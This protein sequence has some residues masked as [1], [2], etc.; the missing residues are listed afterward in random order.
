MA[1]EIEEG[2]KLSH[3]FDEIWAMH[4]KLENSTDPCS[5]DT[6]QVFV[7]YLLILRLYMNSTH[8]L[9]YTLFSILVMLKSAV[10]VDAVTVRV[11]VRVRIG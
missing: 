6:V 8:V 9:S 5:S 1:N 3:L 10:N 11:W 4:E 2:G 7:I